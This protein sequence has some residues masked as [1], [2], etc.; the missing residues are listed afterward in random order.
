MR[1]GNDSSELNCSSQLGTLSMSEILDELMTF[2]ED[3]CGFNIDWIQ[4]LLQC[5]RQGERA[6]EGKFIIGEQHEDNEQCVNSIEK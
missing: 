3:E 1:L 6:G 5:R 2:G 4:D